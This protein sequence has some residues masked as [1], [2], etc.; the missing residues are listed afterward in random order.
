MAQAADLLVQDQL[1]CS[2]CLDTLKDP[3][4]IPCG[5]NYC[6]GCIKGYWDQD[7]N[8]GVYS[9][10]QC[11][12]TF[13]PRPVLKKNT[14]LDEMVEQLKKTGLQAAPPAHY[15]A[16]PGD[17]A[18]DFCTGRKLKAVESCLVC[19]ASYCETH[20]QPHYESLALKKHNL[21]K[22]T[23]NL[24]EKICSCH[25]KAL[26]IY[27]RTDQQFICYLCIIED[28]RGHDT[29]SIEKE[30][31]EKQK[32]LGVTQSKFQQR[33]Q[34]REKELQDLRQAVQSLKRSAQA[35]VEDSERIFTELICSIERRRTEVKE[36][37]R[38]Q[39][40]AEVSRAEGLLEQLE[41]EIAELRRRDTELEHL[42]HTEDHIHFL[43]ST[44]SL[45]VPPG[46]VDL[47]SITINP[48]ISFEAVRKC[49][50][51]LKEHLE[52]VCKG[53]MSKICMACR[54]IGIY[55]C[56]TETGEPSEAR[57]TA[58]EVKT[59]F[60]CMKPWQNKLRL[61]CTHAF[62]AACLHDSVSRVGHQCPVCLKALAVVG[63][64]PEGQ[65]T[66]QYVGNKLFSITYNIP[67]G[68]QTEAHPNPGKPFIG[69]Q[70]AAVLTSTPEGQEVLK[71]LRRAFDQKLVFTV[72]ATDGAGDRVIYADIPHT[73]RPIVLRNPDFLQKVKAALSAKFIE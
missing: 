9:C 27:C 3:A 64:Q 43:Q 16:G 56:S 4:T 10:P 65:M 8:T 63:D 45:C 40:K 17:V 72:A 14:L 1:S 28:H 31:T 7:D 53:E 22:A 30:R 55:G 51:E 37:I 12:E 73:R 71:L 69:I 20:L 36:L 59:C 44:Q 52:D 19:L 54:A 49:V 61:I 41:Q 24:Q 35:A 46:P 33:I 6:M 11:R 5:H 47:S 38:D 62:C 2:I 42:S 34:E 48:H 67:N 23:G 66:E 60:I 21:V 57:G 50:S 13:T 15:Y 70:T 32:Q 58:A 25:D 18:C 26:K 39:E 68:I 29:V